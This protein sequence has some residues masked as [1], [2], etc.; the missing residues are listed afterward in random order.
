MFIWLMLQMIEKDTCGIYQ[1]YFYVNLFHL[2]ENSSTIDE[3]ALNKSII[4]KLLNKILLI[5]KQDT[6][7][8]VETFAEESDI[9]RVS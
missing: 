6:E 3:K 9:E 4:T 2:L 5:G 7:N 1:L 8:K